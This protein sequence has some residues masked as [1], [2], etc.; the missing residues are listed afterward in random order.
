[1][2]N[3]HP[4]LPVLF[5][6]LLP[7]K[8]H[9][10][11][12]SCSPEHVTFAGNTTSGP[13][14]ERTSVNWKR[15]DY[16]IIDKK[17]VSMTYKNPNDPATKINPTQREELAVLEN[18]PEKVV[19]LGGSMA[20]PLTL[21]L[22]VIF[23]QEGNGYTFYVSDYPKMLPKSELNNVSKLYVLKCKEIQ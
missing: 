9:G 13:K 15:I 2:K 12:Y 18:S 14:I 17:A 7:L 11:S 19:M 20:N 3:V 21:T 1:M 5:F 4:F 6:L 8:A 22:D 23:P 10:Q 16:Y